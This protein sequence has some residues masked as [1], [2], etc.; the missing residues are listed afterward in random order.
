MSKTDSP[1]NNDNGQTL[2][3]CLP[4]IV[5]VGGISLLVV[6]ICWTETTP[7]QRDFVQNGSLRDTDV[8]DCIAGLFRGGGRSGIFDLFHL[9]HRTSGM[10]VLAQRHTVAK[11]IGR[12][13]RSVGETLLF[14]SPLSVRIYT[15][16]RTW[17]RLATS[18][19]TALS[20]GD[21]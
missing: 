6:G 7:E 3:L 10:E 19:N 12:R 16:S 17:H 15:C 13:T 8:A 5:E 20:S 11:M 2:V 1:G 18:M 21:S 14:H 4:I 9:Y